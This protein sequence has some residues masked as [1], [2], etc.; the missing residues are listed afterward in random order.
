MFAVQ[1]PATAAAALWPGRKV[2]GACC[3]PCS[4][5][6]QAVEVHWNML[7]VAARLYDDLSRVYH[8]SALQAT[9]V[10]DL[11]R[12]NL[13]MAVAHSAAQNKHLSALEAACGALLLHSVKC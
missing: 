6:D 2:A 1:S 8:L 12:L 7:E 5:T 10:H 11:Q 13:H 4:S 9:A 3:L